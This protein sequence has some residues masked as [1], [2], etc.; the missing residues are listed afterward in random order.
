MKLSNYTVERIE[1][2]P[3]LDPITV[4]CLDYDRAG[5]GKIIIEC[6]GEA[7]SA[8]WDAMGKNRTVRQFVASVEDEYLVRCL[9]KNGHPEYRM[10]IA[11]AVIAR[12]KETHDE[13]W[14]RITAK[15]EPTNNVRYEYPPSYWAILRALAQN[16][17]RAD[18]A[19][20]NAVTRYAIGTIRGALSTMGTQGLVQRD[21]R[22]WTITADGV[23]ALAQDGGL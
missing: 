6:F 18:V 17:A 11:R 4:V 16:P 12:C 14:S 21:S 5:V 1:D 8:G 23:K 9:S 19:N 15:P 20:L 2:A 7:W 22:G 10:R 3:N 13:A